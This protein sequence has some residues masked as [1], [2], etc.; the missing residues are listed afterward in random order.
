MR[1]VSGCPWRVR[2]CAGKQAGCPEKGHASPLLCVHLLTSATLVYEGS[3]WLWSE[4][5]KI[6]EFLKPVVLVHRACKVYTLSPLE[7]IRFQGG[8]TDAVFSA[9]K[10]PRQE[11]ECSQN[12]GLLS[13]RGRSGVTPRC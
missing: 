11:T 6:I 2:S 8:N 7:R 13:R 12:A 3:A 1:S 5:S 4:L 9:E 10:D